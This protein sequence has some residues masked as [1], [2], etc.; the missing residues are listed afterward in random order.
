MLSDQG[1]ILTHFS[2]VQELSELTE[3]VGLVV[4]SSMIPRVINR[5]M[6]HSKYG[7]V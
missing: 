2:I 3:G 5:M 7:V 6:R 1:I 4:A